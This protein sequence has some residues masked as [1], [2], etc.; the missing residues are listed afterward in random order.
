M[1]HRK[2]CLLLIIAFVGLISSCRL[3]PVQ[4]ESKAADINTVI[5]SMTNIMV[6]D[7]TNP[8]LASRFFAYASL[9]GYQV[10]VQNNSA[11]KSMRGVLKDYPVI[12]KPAIKAYSYRLAALIAMLETAANMQPS[13]KL[14]DSV[15]VLF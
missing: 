6:H 5:S 10:I 2:A 13:G 3:K 14:L 9:A 1:K 8:P 11:F 4:E 7:V 15:K 12:Q